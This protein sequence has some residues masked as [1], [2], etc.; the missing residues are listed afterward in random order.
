MLRIGVD[1]KER[2][3][4]AVGG[5]PEPWDVPPLPERGDNCEDVTYAGV[6]RVISSWEAVEV[7]LA[8]LYTVFIGRPHEHHAIRAYGSPR[9][10]AD[11]LV[12]VRRAADQYFVSAPDQAVEG[13]VTELLERVR[14]Y[15]DRRNE[16]AHGIV[17][18][19]SWVRAL[20]DRLVSDAVGKFQYCLVPPHYTFRKF[21]GQN[22]PTYAYTSAELLTLNERLFWLAQEVSDLRQRVAP[23]DE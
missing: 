6:G 1:S 21:D 14:R 3:F 2:G 5:M 8:H 7:Q 10:F 17:R 20:R 13:D 22:Q 11:R 9:I 16:V 23:E 4:A 18:Q 12:L 15:S 19:M